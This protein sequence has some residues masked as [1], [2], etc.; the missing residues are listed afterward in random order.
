MR[1]LKPIIVLL[2]IVLFSCEDSINGP[3]GS[4]LTYE[5]LLLSVGEEVVFGTINEDVIKVKFAGLDGNS[6]VFEHST[7]MCDRCPLYSDNNKLELIMYDGKYKVTFK[8][9]SAKA[10]NISLQL[11]K[12]E[13][14]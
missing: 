11:Y 14:L 5:P 4:D 12:Y 13:R 8:Y 2:V 9:N 1:L 7:N 10:N 3:I 6:Y